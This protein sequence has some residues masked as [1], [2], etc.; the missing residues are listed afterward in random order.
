MERLKKLGQELLTSR[1]HV[2]N[3]PILISLLSSCLG[4]EA[5]F[6]QGLEALI[7][8]QAFFLPLL[9]T[10]LATSAVKE[11]SERLKKKRKRSQDGETDDGEKAE[12]IYRKWLWSKYRELLRVVRKIVASSIPNPTLRVVAMDALME[13]ARHQK[14]GRFQTRIYLRLISSLV[15]S[16]AFDDVILTILLPK[17]FKYKDICYFSYSGLAELVSSSI[18]R[19]YEDE[20]TSADNEELH[21][22]K[23]SSPMVIQNVY[24]FLSCIPLPS[25]EDMEESEEEMW[26]NFNGLPSDK[27]NSRGFGKQNTQQTNTDQTQNASKKASSGRISAKRMRSKMSKA[28]MSFLKLPLP[29]EVYKKVLA[30]LHKTVVPYLTNPILLSDFLTQSYDI[31]GVTSVMALN[32]L[33][34]LITEHG[35]EYPDFYNKLYALLEPSIFMAKYRSHFLSFWIDV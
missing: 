31:G 13:F 21:I 34:I 19:K 27:D 14:Q 11:A 8:L 30:N 29:V 33:F 16:K 25:E 35:L 12:D 6:D 5:I 7:T 15:H 23:S 1:A 17:Y 18:S 4:N 2:N 20:D 3:A 24:K 26:S 9:R 32:S 22:S 10:E 28:W